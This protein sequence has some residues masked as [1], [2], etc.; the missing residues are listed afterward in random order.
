[1]SLFKKEKL[2]T[3]N[4]LRSSVDSRYEA[5]TPV[6]NIKNGQEYKAA[7]DW[8]LSQADVHN[9]AISGPYGSGK[10]SV[11]ESYLSESNRDNVVRISLAAF[12]LDEMLSGDNG[13]KTIDTDKLETGILKQLFYSVETNK[14]PQSRYRKLQTIKESSNRVISVITMVILGVV[15]AFV[16]P[17]K[18][19]TFVDAI[20]A[21][22]II[23]AASECVGITVILWYALSCFIGWVRK[24]GS[25]QEIKI[26]DKASIKNSNENKESIFNKNMDE[27]VY[28]FEMTGKSLVVI[29]DLD[30]FESTNIFVALR[31]LNSILNN[32]EKIAGRVKF[33][34][35]IKDD[36]FDEDEER[37]KFFDFIIP[38]V[39]YISSTNSCEILRD[40]LLFDDAKNC[41]KISDISGGFVSMIS[42]YISDARELICICNEFHVFKNTLKGN[43]NL[44]LNDEKMFAL[45]VFKNRYPKDFAELEDESD[46]SIVR[47]AFKNKASFVET[48]R[49][50]VSSKKEEE[51]KKL[52][53]IEK[54]AIH[55][56]RELKIVLL[57][58]LANHAGAVTQLTF[59]NNNHPLAEI[60]ADEFD[61]NQLKGKQ[62]VV[63]YVYANGSNTVNISNI[64]ETVK[65]AGEDYFGRIDRLVKGVEKCKEESRKTI[66][67]FEQKMNGLR[68][69][70]IK[71]LID[72]FG[73]NFLDEEVRN[74]DLLVFLLRNGYLDE[75]YVNYINYFHP[76]SITK[77]EMNFILGVRNRRF[78]GG[79]V[80]TLKNVS[81]IFDL[82]QDYE[83]KQREVLNFDLVDYV[84]EQK[85]ESSAMELLFEQLSDHSSESM[86]FIKAYVDRD[87]NK[88]VF[89]R[90]LCNANTH[91]WADIESDEGIPL[92]TSY[93]YLVSLLMYADMHDV[94]A[95]DITD[96]NDESVYGVLSAFLM[97]N[98]GVL[99][100]IC[101]APID[102]QIELISELDVVFDNVELDGVED[103]VKAEIFDNN[104]YEINIV[105]LRRLF[106]WK[107]PGQISDFEKK[108][109]TVITALDY[110][111]LY[112]YVHENLEEYVK[113]VLLKLDCDTEEELDAV[114]ELIECLIP[115]NED[116]A[117]KVL[118]KER[119]KW[120]EISECCA[121]IEEG[122]DDSKKKVWNYLLA[123]DRV[124]CSWENLA[125]YYEIYGASAE[126]G[127]YVNSH[128]N[129]LLDDL[130]SEY[131]TPEIKESVLLSDL[132]EENFRSYISKIEMPEFSGKLSML[133]EMKVR[134][135]IEEGILPFT[136]VFWEEMKTVAPDCRVS[137]AERYKDEFI[138]HLNEI[139]IDVVEYNSLLKNK[140]FDQDEI[141]NIMKILPAGDI[142]KDTAMILRELTFRIDKTYSD[143]AWALLDK[144]NK[145]QLLL[146]QIDNYENEDLPDMF[147]ELDDVYKQ[148]T[149]RTKHKFKFAYT[150]FNKKLLDA[151]DEKGYIS[152]VNEDWD[153]HGLIKKEKEHVLI[154]YVK[155]A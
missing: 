104:R 111:P 91:L 100:G 105:M 7:L 93:R 54:D 17:E 3:D 52:E 124:V 36:M 63:R 44:D 92:E 57:S 75:T 33:V 109:Y 21:Q 81:R 131:L 150:D 46:S 29:E 73:L 118:E 74:N 84:L 149:E 126:W 60:L 16:A 143:A 51:K 62:I 28:F 121:D 98:P 141:L 95:L 78:D 48:R 70:S 112:D 116:L 23:F 68:A 53:S 58:F 152:S 125:S 45:I 1:M 65:K 8:A 15:I 61:V 153:E 34:Y 86:S 83:F 10:S 133:G 80:Y 6:N 114:N 99:K 13:N 11:I 20:F 88:D 139:E 24:N 2:N 123:K 155:A 82:L 145:Y 138:E 40:K 135:M 90:A 77:E 35:A 148:L 59:A 144:E 25:I 85:S 56:V 108:N 14:I 122:A 130:D 79:Y 38:I 115:N 71:Q 94:M 129:P 55:S 47:M 146:N 136:T 117:F 89:I 9:I 30:R 42:P 4:S 5:L 140:C 107:A 64:E 76:N 147:N 49:S 12:N 67:E 43:Q 31:E 110:D 151:L 18:V 96:S 103:R 72:E 87:E 134:V 39:P 106:E 127:K 26:L 50:I 137:Y 132:S 142:T 27:I 102:K 66:E 97:N 22:N 113:N 37:T 41:S 154:G 101:D 119:V 32:N 128:V 19:T 69:Y 120:P